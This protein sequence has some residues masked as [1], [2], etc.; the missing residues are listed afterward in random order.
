[1]HTF[2]VDALANYHKLSSFKQHGFIVS[3]FCRS[4][5]WG[6]YPGD[7]IKVSASLCSFLEV[8]ES[9]L[10]LCPFT[11]LTEL[12]SLTL[13]DLR[14]LLLAGCQQRT[15]FSLERSPT[16]LGFHPS[17][18]SFHLESQQLWGHLLSHCR[19]LL[20]LPFYLFYLKQER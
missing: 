10:S 15:V 1:M 9:E 19:S 5:S 12:S 18:S 8:L 13:M 6:R 2:P 20:L 17:S 3:E 14:P 16:F 7:K 4:G 11:S